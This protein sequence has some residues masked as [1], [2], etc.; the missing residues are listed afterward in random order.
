MAKYRCSKCKKQYFL[1][2]D[3]E[4]CCGEDAEVVEENQSPQQQ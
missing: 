2:V 4:D 1:R 3:A